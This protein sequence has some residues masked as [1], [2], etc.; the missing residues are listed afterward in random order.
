MYKGL[1]II[2]TNK[3]TSNCDICCFDCS[4]QKTQKIDMATTKKIIKN[5]IE[6]DI[7]YI[8]FTGGEPFI[9]LDEITQIM[10]HYKKKCYF[11]ITTNGYWAETYDETERILTDLKN[12]GLGSIKI[13]IDKYHLEY[14]DKEKI[15]NI[16]KVCKKID[17]KLV[18][19]AT[20]LKNDIVGDIIDYFKEYLTKAGVFFHPCYRVGR[21][22]KIYDEDK[23]ISS[24]NICFKCPEGFIITVDFN[25]D[26]YPCGS[27]YGMNKVRKI[28]NVF[29]KTFNEL[30][31]ASEKSICDINSI[32]K[33]YYRNYENKKFSDLCEVCYE[34]YKVKNSRRSQ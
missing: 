13:S 9:Y 29:E 24:N 8:G 14:V 19:G 12:N 21:A 4:P 27:I 3:C 34:Y 33:F 2:Y 30:L 20:I 1:G 26:I 22:S 23:F 5:A 32:K 16:L 17:L 11:T 18:V 28:G 15:I 7:H 6:K 10:K 31:E 25:G